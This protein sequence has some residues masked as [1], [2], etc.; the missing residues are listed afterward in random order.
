MIRGEN[1][2]LSGWMCKLTQAWSGLA[3]LGIYEVKRKEAWRVE[4]KFWY[5]RGA[6]SFLLES[7][8]A[9]QQTNLELHWSKR[10]N[11]ACTKINK[12]RT[13]DNWL[14]IISKMLDRE[15]K[16]DNWSEPSRHMSSLVETHD[17]NDKTTCSLAGSHA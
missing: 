15:R 7:W 16:S 1:V 11:V 13:I 17:V 3:W 12:L 9:K 8:S 6:R 4:M 5:G 2:V 14:T 10:K